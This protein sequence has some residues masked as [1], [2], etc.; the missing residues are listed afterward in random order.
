MKTV[1]IGDIHGNPV[2]KNIIWHEKPKRVIFLGDYFDA[3]NI[4]P[5]DQLINFKAIL[6]YRDMYPE[7]E[8]VLL[9]G[10]HDHHYLP[11]IGNSNTSGY[12]SAFAMQFGEE[13]M[14]ADLRMAYQFDNYLFSHAGISH[15]F[16][17][18]YF[19]DEKDI[20]EVAENINALFHYKPKVFCFSEVYTDPY[21][22]DVFQSPIWIRPRSLMNDNKNSFLKHN[23]IQIF[24]HT[25]MKRV[26]AKGATT[27][28]RYFAIDTLATSGEYMIIDKG[29]KFNSYKQ[30]L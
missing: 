29:I 25:Q 9:T 1:V 7:I 14:K 30:H 19:N 6:E 12:N 8:F 16:Y 11:Y 20:E 24:G 17:T 28:G 5:I 10:N 18:K 2:W 13:L 22:D 27:N 15:T 3:Y 23:Y 26:D 21:G 4:S